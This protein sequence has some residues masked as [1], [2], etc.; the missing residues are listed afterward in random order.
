MTF[1]RSARVV[2]RRSLSPRVSELPLEVGAMR[3]FRW[4]AGPYVT[5][6]LR[7]A[8]AEPVGELGASAA[9]CSSR[10]RARSTTYSGRASSKPPHAISGMYGSAC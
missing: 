7:S 10:V 2:G 1:R 4:R 5:L 9:W 6:Q 3:V 8:L